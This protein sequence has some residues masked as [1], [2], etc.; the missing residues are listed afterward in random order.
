MTLI[1]NSDLNDC[2]YIRRISGL[3]RED[4][5]M[6]SIGNEE[7]TISRKSHKNLPTN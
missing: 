6:W 1:E 3:I 5:F 4:E 7:Q 2:N